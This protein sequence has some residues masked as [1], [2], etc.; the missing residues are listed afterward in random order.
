M[1]ENRENQFILRCVHVLFIFD[2]ILQE[3]EISTSNRTV[4]SAIKTIDLTSGN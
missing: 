4:S 2:E 1:Y 3:K